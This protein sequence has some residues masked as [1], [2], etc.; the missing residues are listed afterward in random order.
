MPLASPGN[1]QAHAAVLSSNPNEKDCVR[2]PM[3]A[4]QSAPI[5]N[6]FQVVADIQEQMEDSG[7]STEVVDAIVSRGLAILFGRADDEG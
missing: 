7:Y 5:T 1:S 3:S 2:T 6:L 4:S